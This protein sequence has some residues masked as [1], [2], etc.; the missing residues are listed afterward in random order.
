MHPTQV[1]ADHASGALP[2]CAWPTAVTAAAL[3]WA[4]MM[5]AG[6]VSVALGQ[7]SPFL[8]ELFHDGRHLIGVPCH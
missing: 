3:F 8:H 7:S 5:E 2:I 4:V 6:A 1:P